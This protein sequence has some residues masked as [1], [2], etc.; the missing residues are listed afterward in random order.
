LRRPVVVIQSDAYSASRLATVIVA[1]LTSNTGLAAAPG[2]V[3]VPA[4][5]SGLSR[6]SV[7]NVTAVVTLDR[8]HLSEPIGDLP[9]YLLVEVDQ[10]LRRVLDL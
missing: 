4:T 7:V 10:G 5:T 1:V 8:A 2:N 3:F 6:D 9:P